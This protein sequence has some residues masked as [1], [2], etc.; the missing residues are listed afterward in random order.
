MTGP[1]PFLSPWRPLVP[2]FVPLSFYTI[3]L[4]VCCDWCPAPSWAR[5]V[6][7]GVS[8]SARGGHSTALVGNLFIVVGGQYYA[9]QSTSPA[10]PIA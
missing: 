5:P 7:N 3:S 10:T 4:C 6:M 1:P 9:G 2:T 8:P